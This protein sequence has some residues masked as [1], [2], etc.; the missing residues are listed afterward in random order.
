MNRQR[1][2]RLLLILV[3]TLI[4]V[5]QVFRE[6]S[7]ERPQKF[8]TALKALVPPIGFIYHYIDFN[9][10]NSLSKWEEKVFQGKV[11]YWIEFEKRS[12]Y[13]HALSKGAASA[14]FYKIKYKITDY[15]F[16]SW[17][18]RVEKFPDK[19]DTTDSK[20][21]DDF[22]A[23]FYV[24]FLSKFFTNFRCVEYVWDESVPENTMMDSPYTEQ[25]KQIVIQS[26]SAA[27][28]NWVS[29]TRNVLEDYERLFGEKPS[30]KVAAI[31]LMTDSEGTGA[32]AEAFFDDIRIGKSAAESAS[33]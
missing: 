22:A 11:S 32:E 30:M 18:W 10:K 33:K 20:K 5:I 28:E 13:V 2:I 14:I 23:R 8:K 3:P 26:G 17:K 21:R 19:K 25:I 24:V 6:P 4:L 1:W 15:P 29:E 31:A 7:F 9:Q 12:G 16:I 27:A